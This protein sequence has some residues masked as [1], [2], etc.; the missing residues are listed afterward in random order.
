M[1]GSRLFSLASI[2]AICAGLLPCV[3]DVVSS[4]QHTP[5]LAFNQDCL[6]NRAMRLNALS[7]RFDGFFE[8]V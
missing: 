6:P 7:Q 3:N 4:R 1:P 5:S 2:G 8:I